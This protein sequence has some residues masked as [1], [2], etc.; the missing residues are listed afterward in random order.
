MVFHYVETSLVLMKVIILQKV[1]VPKVILSLKFIPLIAQCFVTSQVEN[2]VQVSKLCSFHDPSPR[3]WRLGT[4]LGLRAGFSV[5]SLFSV[6]TDAIHF[7]WLKFS[8]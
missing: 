6:C 1:I 7:G 2:T 8:A 3:V 4:W 5:Q